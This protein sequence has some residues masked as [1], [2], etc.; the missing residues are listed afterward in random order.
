MSHVS[1]LVLAVLPDWL[2]W[3]GGERWGGE[4][5]RCVLKRG[6]KTNSRGFF[7]LHF[8]INVHVS[9]QTAFKLFSLT[10]KARC[11]K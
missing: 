10:F 11:V 2:T 6:L 3:S 5:G 4:V 7:L 1:D 9:P 8:C